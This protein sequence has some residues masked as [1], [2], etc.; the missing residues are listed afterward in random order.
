MTSQPKNVFIS[1]SHDDE[2]HKAWVLKLASDLRVNG[3]N[4]ILDQWDTS[5]GASLT[6]FMEKGLMETDRVLVVCTDKYIEKANNRIG[7]VGY[8]GAILTGELMISQDTQKFI[9][10]IRGVSHERKV[11]TCLSGR[12]YIDF[13]NDEDYQ[14]LLKNLLHEIYDVPLVEKP[15]LGKNPFAV[16]TDTLS[17]LNKDST[18]FFQE[19]FSKAFPGVRGVEWFKDPKIAIQRLCLLLENPITFKDSH[20]IWWW[21]H[22]DL[23]IENFEKIDDVSALMDGQELLID[24]IAAVNAGSYYQSFVYVK[25]KAS[26]KS[27]LYE[28][29][30]DDELDR[31][32]YAREE[33]AVFD[34][35]LI[36]RAEYDDGAAI[37]DGVPVPTNGNASLRIRYITPYNFL[38]APLNSPINNAKFDSTRDEILTKILRE[39]ASLDDFVEVFMHLPK[40]QTF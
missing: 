5:L 23:H 32:G 27:G 3:I 11:P 13:T 25:T 17:N 39:E 1:Y 40:R 6:Q 9:P 20:P 36:N 8:E 22:G 7:G 15:K 37:I 2:K 18:V 30:I 34:G 28:Y 24:E 4:A 33:F 10:V 21:R 19:R 14:S 31:W 26:E 29:T 35:H 16:T 38:I 12:L